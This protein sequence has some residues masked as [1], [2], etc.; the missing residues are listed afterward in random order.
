M[1]K[2]V[3][4]V[5]LESVAINSV[6]SLSSWKLWFSAALADK[7]FVGL[8]EF[9]FVFWTVQFE[10]S[11]T[12]LNWRRLLDEIEHPILFLALFPFV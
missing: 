4:F 7:W 3:Q 10:T 8:F 6:S 9:V 12:E 5:L 1:G 2:L 11:V